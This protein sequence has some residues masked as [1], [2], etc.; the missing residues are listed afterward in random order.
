MRSETEWV[1]IFKCVDFRAFVFLSIASVSDHLI[2]NL[3]PLS[4]WHDLSIVRWTPSICHQNERE[5]VYRVF[6]EQ[7]RCPFYLIVQAA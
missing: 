4:T 1:Q 2:P 5:A 7:C 6:N 3:S